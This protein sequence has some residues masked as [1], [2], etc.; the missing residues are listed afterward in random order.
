MRSIFMMIRR[1]N[2][3]HCPD[4]TRTNQRLL[5]A[6]ISSSNSLPLLRLLLHLP[7]PL[8]DLISPFPLS[9]LRLLLAIPKP[10]SYPL[11]PALC[12]LIYFMFCIVVR[13]TRFMLRVVVRLLS[14]GRGI[15]ETL[16]CGGFV[17]G[18]C[19]FSTRGGG[20]GIG[21]SLI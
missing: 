2:T 14:F 5:P 13:L 15:R 8:S 6:E 19:R 16:F 18:E 10:T 20:G 21:A 3:I 9:L 1:Y 12:R 17:G 7:R 4:P 11:S